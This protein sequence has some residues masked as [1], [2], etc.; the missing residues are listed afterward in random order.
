LGPALQRTQK[1]VDGVAV[2]GRDVCAVEDD[3]RGIDRERRARVA[4]FA[5][6]ATVEVACQLQNRSVCF[7]D[8]RD[9]ARSDK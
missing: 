6:G 9:V 7:T 1:F 3:R 5:R 8:D 4:K 2:D